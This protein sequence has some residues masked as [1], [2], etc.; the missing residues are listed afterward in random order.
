MNL[1][2]RHSAWLIPFALIISLLPLVSMQEVLKWDVMDQ[3]YPCRA[4]ISDC[5]R[6][7]EWPWW[8]PYINL[9]YPFSADPQS[10]AFYPIT[11]LIAAT[12]G[13]SVYTITLEWFV[14]LLIAGFGMR[15]LLR[16]FD[17]EQTEATAFAICYML[18]GAF[19]SNAQHLTWMVSAAWLPWVAAG[20]ALI[21]K[22]QGSFRTLIWTGLSAFMCL[23]GGYPAFS[24][25][26]NYMLFASFLI[27]LA[28]PSRSLTGKDKFKVTIQ[29]VIT[30]AIF[31]LS[32]L[33]F[34]LIFFEAKPFISRTAL[35]LSEVYE[36]A[37]PKAGL[38]TLLYP[39]AGATLNHPWGA[40][41]SM[42]GVYFGF[43][44]FPL[45]L[46]AVIVKRNALCIG[47]FIIAMVNLAAA[48]G[49]LTPIRSWFYHLLPYM[50]MFRNG[51]LFRFFF[52]IPM[53]LLAG[54]GWKTW[55][56]V[57]GQDKFLFILVLLC[58]GLGIALGAMAFSKE[59]S[60]LTDFKFSLKIFYEFNAQADLWS[61]IAN[62]FIIY[63]PLIWLP[64]IFIS[65]KG[66]TNSK[67]LLALLILDMFLATQI[68]TS[69]TITFPRSMHSL[70]TAISEHSKDFPSPKNQSL[71]RT[72]HIGDGS[73][74]PIWYNN[75]MFRKVPANDGF[76]NFQ[77]AGFTAID[78][79]AQRWVVFDRP[80]VSWTN[81]STDG[82]EF[83]SFGP[84][85]T[86][87]FIKNSEK[88]VLI[89]AQWNYPG[90]T[91]EI[92]KQEV[93]LLEN[94]YGMMQVT[95]PK[96][97]H[98]VTFKYKPSYRLGL[99]IFSA[100]FF[101]LMFGLLIFAWLR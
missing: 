63:L 46:Y 11:W 14:T 21:L 91:V 12:A 81:K 29:L 35:S 10:G 41:I 53:I 55:K 75:N 73:L 51:A 100:A 40:D 28:L 98:Q 16:V 27:F 58:S 43:I 99:V 69:A 49:P 72:S 87:A 83:A 84:N 36:N 39:W 82:I 61:H 62:Q 18:C 89:L 94:A 86:T 64:F 70:Q 34:L 101:L 92:D 56:N 33:A 85:H 97:D 9:G 26:L 50:D 47:L 17:V 3:F 88:R 65:W 6:T 32:S 2:L 42:I 5:F 20:F 25:I 78:T 4:F 7:G 44:T 1:H 66:I 95:V 24:I 48:L 57:E 74:E 38:A 90:W 15:K 22:M 76:N 37:L 71:T 60:L 54:I 80:L 23:T 59:I 13:Y 19:L 96:G 8:N 67:V 93:K 30:Y 68:Q 79:T 31:I 45:A 52:I 77:L